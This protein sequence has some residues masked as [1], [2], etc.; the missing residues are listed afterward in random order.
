MMVLYSI[1]QEEADGPPLLTEND[2][3][4]FLPK[5]ERVGTRTIQAGQTVV[6]KK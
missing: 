5:A 6:R 1:E 4:P 3:D 2:P